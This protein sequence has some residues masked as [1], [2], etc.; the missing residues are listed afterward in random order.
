V[1][2]EKVADAPAE[3]TIVVA[4]HN[5]AAYLPE[6]MASLTGQVGVVHRVVVVDDGSRDDTSVVLGS[7]G[8][9]VEVRSLPISRG[10]SAAR[11]AGAEGARTVWLAFTDDDCLPDPGWLRALL[12]TATETGAGVVQGRTQPVDVPHGRWDRSIDVRAPGGL[13]ET[14]NLLVRRDL[15]EAAD[16]FP[17][18]SLLARAGR[19]FGEDVVLGSR[20]A[21][22]AGSAFDDTAVVRHRWL[23]AT[24]A[25][26]LAGR[27]RLVGFPALLQAAPSVRALTAGPFLTSRTARTWLALAGLGAARRSPL[28]I[29]SVV[30]WLLA[31]WPTARGLSDARHQMPF[32][33]AQLAAADLLAIASLAEGS[34]RSGRLLL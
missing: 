2:G 4:T 17:E 3:V 13:F 26:Y 28:A 27:R 8:D 9:G 21:S 32:R 12:D 30:P 6:L 22:L 29:G 14:C 20:V 7:C 34:I 15:F 1:T 31:V 33:L 11:N 19:G 16:G 10:P 18:L 23:P 25:D 24:Y 5:R